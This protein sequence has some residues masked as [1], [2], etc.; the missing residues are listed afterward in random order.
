MRYARFAPFPVW[1]L[2][3]VMGFTACTDS[4]DPIQVFPPPGPVPASLEIIGPSQGQVGDDIALAA[5]VR[6]AA[7]DTLRQVAVTWSSSDTVRIPLSLVKTASGASA[8]SGA[9]VKPQRI[10]TARVIVSA[11]ALRDT[12]VFTS[13]L[14][15]YA[16]VFADTVSAS[17]RQL[18]LDA[19]QDAHA[20]HQTMLGR[21]IAESTTVTGAFSAPGCNNGGAAAYTG[22]HAVVFC[23]ANPGWKNNGPVR[24]QKI[25]QH[26]LFHV[27][28]FE[29]H[30][31]GNAATAGATWLIEGSAEWMGYKGIDALGLLSFETA[32]GCQI[33]ESSD[34]ATR[35]PPG[36]PPLSSVETQAAFQSTQGPLYTHSMLA[37]EYL[38]QTAGLL[39]FRSY[40]E[41]IAA[42]TEWHAAF[43]SAFG[44]STTT[45]YNQFPT[46]LSARPV[47]A[48]YLCG[49]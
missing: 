49:I 46:W 15:P 38:I 10:A 39:A 12:V 29:N 17:Q 27:W 25:V 36:L 21:L 4:T 41:A 42:G 13:S 44:I 7:G 23:L 26:E 5:V 48:S 43:Q 18:I 30:W 1:A 6:D 14:S 19:V 11:G 2:F 35:T 32:L 28:Q 33:K 31:T 24:Q 47:P 8:A 3:L 9:I 37:A 40:V 45:F 22:P 34:F 20:F 16:F